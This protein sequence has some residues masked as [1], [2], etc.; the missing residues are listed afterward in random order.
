MLKMCSEKWKVLSIQFIVMLCFL[1]LSLSLSLAGVTLTIG[2]G[3]GSLGS[4]DNPVEVILNNPNDEVNG[5][6]VD[7]CDVGN[8]LT[9]SGCTTT[10]RT[11]HFDCYTTEM[12]NGCVR[13]IMISNE[14]KE[15]GVP[16]MI[17]VGNGPVF[18]LNYDVS[19]A[20]KKGECK[21]LNPENITVSKYGTSLEVTPVAGEFCFICTSDEDCEDELYCNGDDTCEGGFCVHSGDPCLLIPDTVCDEETDSCVTTTTVPV[22]TTTTTATGPAYAVSISPSSATLDS[23]ASLQF[24]VIT[25]YGGEEVEGS[26]SWEIVSGSTIGSMIDGNGLFTAGTNNT[27]SAIEETVRV[28][29]TAHE[30]KSATATVTIK[31]KGEIPPE[32]EVTINPSS[33]T[34]PS[35]D[36]LTLLAGTTGD[37]CLPGD[38]EWSIDTDIASVVDQ[39]GNY[40]AGSNTTGS[41]ATDV[42]TVVDHANSDISSSATIHV[43]NEESVKNA[44]VFPARLLGSRWIP[45]PYMLLILGEDTNFNLRSTVSFEPGEDILKLSQFGFGKVMFVMVFLGANP[46]EG[47]VNVII[48]TA[49]EVAVGEITIGLLPLIFN[50]DYSGSAGLRVE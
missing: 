12:T 21:D 1:T 45:L 14:E 11:S 50:E 5:I 17:E 35:G 33:A 40:T 48:T 42:I 41:Q 13:V 43:E 9:C 44:S 28:T 20:A 38:Y 10:E 22:S 26:Y 24:G 49:G 27:Q 32:C 16:Y 46:Q 4:N 3:S 6:Q 36:S 8:F 47:A 37:E 2:D 30:N 29:D 25:T 23:D 39:E 34:V 15:P 31:V 19:G 18:T 7:V